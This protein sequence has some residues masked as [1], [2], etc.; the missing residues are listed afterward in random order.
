MGMYEIS[1]HRVYIPTF[2]SH[3]DN[4]KITDTSWVSFP[5][6]NTSFC[7]LRDPSELSHNREPD[8]GDFVVCTTAFA[9]HKPI[10]VAGD[11]PFPHDDDTA[12]RNALT[13]C[14]ANIMIAM[15]NLEVAL[16]QR[17][18]ERID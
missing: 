15:R 13:A 9:Q 10:R 8:H 14:S 7:S 18:S 1:Q 11:T 6:V 12:G 3:A 4:I 17:V 16:T 2:V 5:Q